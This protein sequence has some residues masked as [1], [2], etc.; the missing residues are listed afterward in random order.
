MQV[1]ER[2][3]ESI[4]AVVERLF[5]FIV[6]VYA[7][8][9][10]DLEVGDGG[11]IDEVVEMLLRG[12]QRLQGSLDGCFTEPGERRVETGEG[13]INIMEE[14]LPSSAGPSSIRHVV[15]LELYRDLSLDHIYAAPDRLEGVYLLLSYA[16]YGAVL[17]R[18]DRILL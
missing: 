16:T 5:G 9:K 14:L 17:G 15:Y 10:T 8:A 2:S 7:G 11:A 3:I 1:V 12:A 4:V 13:R 18:Q 6:S